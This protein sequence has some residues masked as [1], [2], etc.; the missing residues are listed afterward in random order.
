[1]LEFLVTMSC[2]GSTPDAKVVMVSLHKSCGKMAAQ[3]NGNNNFHEQ[4]NTGFQH[5]MQHPI[6]SL[7]LGDHV[8]VALSIEETRPQQVEDYFFELLSTNNE[9]AVDQL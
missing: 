7:E 3:I 5:F 2:T 4:P 8:P 9:M 1:M 6:T